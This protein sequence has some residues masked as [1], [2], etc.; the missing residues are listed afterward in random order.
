MIYKTLSE[1]THLN[2]I[3]IV[4][5]AHIKAIQQCISHGEDAK[6]NIAISIKNKGLSEHKVSATE[7]KEYPKFQIKR[8]VTVTQPVMNGKETISLSTQYENI[9]V[10]QDGQIVTFDELPAAYEEK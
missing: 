3:T 1:L 5:E 2:G 9:Y 4:D 8:V 10:D 6:I 7:V